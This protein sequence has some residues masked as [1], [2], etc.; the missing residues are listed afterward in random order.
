MSE[1]IGPLA[2]GEQ[3]EEVFIG[4]EWAHSRNFSEETARLVDAE[5]KR[6]IEEARQRCHTLLEE[7]LTALHDIANALLERETISGD[8]IDILMRGEKL[9]PERGNGGAPANS[10][11]TPPAGN[12]TDGA[13]AAQSPQASE[14]AATPAEEFTLEAEE[15]EKRDDRA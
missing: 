11:T 8:D 1:A 9:P 10:G 12:T 7:N 3:G 2:I 6:I 4:R 15:P 5:V 13:K 14:D